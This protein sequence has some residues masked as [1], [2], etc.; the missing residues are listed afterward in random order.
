MKILVTG[1]GGFLGTFFRH[2]ARIPGAEYVYGTT[3][4]AADG[5][6]QFEDCYSDVA[7]LGRV[8][9]VI[10]FA[11]VIPP[12]FAAADYENVF[13]KNTE[14]MA[15]LTDFALVGGVGKFVYIS[16]FGS[17]D[18]PEALDIKDYYTLSK[19]TGELFCKM[20]HARGVET[21]SLRVSAPYGEYQ[22]S[23]TVI[24]LFIDQALK[25]QKLHVFG[26]GA[27]TQNFTYA[28]DVVR[29]VELCF[30]HPLDGLVCNIV[31]EKSTSMLELAETVNEL[32]HNP[33][34]ISVGER[35]DPQESYRANY[36][37]SEA[38]AAIGYRPVFSLREGLERRIRWQ[39]E[40]S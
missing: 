2:F 35:E 33:A 31:A 4:A 27:R 3:R 34:G 26:S 5:L 1:A 22:R 25:Q 11:S 21:A 29:A 20:L 16:G 32:T 37:Y 23:R 14:M 10:H 9:A 8:D 40:L 7:K 19:T 38:A 17:M 39:K 30:A 24:N 36:D 6:T 13:R 12:S 28:G 18:H 15:N